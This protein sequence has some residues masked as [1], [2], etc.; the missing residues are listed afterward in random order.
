MALA[1][2]LNYL[3]LSL[4]WYTQTLLIADV[5]TK[6]RIFIK[7]RKEKNCRTLFLC[8]SLSVGGRLQLASHAVWRRLRKNEARC[9][10]CEPEVSLIKSLC[11]E[12]RK[13]QQLLVLFPCS[14]QVPPGAF[15]REVHRADMHGLKSQQLRLLTGHSSPALACGIAMSVSLDCLW[16]IRPTHEITGLFSKMELLTFQWHSKESIL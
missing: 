14:Y 6:N 5:W 3:C 15:W 8:I 10:D 11:W 1:N 16:L 4:S 9:V 13:R 7:L 12:K 2:F